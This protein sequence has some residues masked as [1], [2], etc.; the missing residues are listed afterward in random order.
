MATGSIA[1]LA[2]P[3]KI[4]LAIPPPMSKGIPKIAARNG[5]NIQ[6]IDNTAANAAMAIVERMAVIE[7]NA[8]KGPSIEAAPSTSRVGNANLDTIPRML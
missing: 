4:P 1:M 3:Q 2:A 8:I 7:K 6:L 5:T